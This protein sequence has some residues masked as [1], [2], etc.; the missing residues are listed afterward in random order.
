MHWECGVEV[1][2]V[3]APVQLLHWCTEHGFLLHGSPRLLKTLD[4]RQPRDLSK[5]EGSR[6]AVYMSDDPAL[7]MYSAIAVGDRGGYQVYRGRGATYLTLDFYVRYRS[8]IAD[9]GY[10][11]V[12]SREPH[13]ELVDGDY[14]SDRP[15][16]PVACLI[17]RQTDFPYT[18][19]V[20]QPDPLSGFSS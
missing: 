14:L 5:P 6:T 12:I 18:I 16:M 10:I 7:S 8:N 20:A 3:Q 19:R 15:V 4:P 17:F 1:C 9:H 2:A 11:Y 13:L